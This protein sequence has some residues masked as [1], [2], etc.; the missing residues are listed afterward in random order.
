MMHNGDEIRSIT[1]MKTGSDLGMYGSYS[2]FI[3]HKGFSR[4]VGLSGPKGS[5]LMTSQEAQESA[6]K[7]LD[8]QYTYWR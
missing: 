6:E 7:I 2:L 8:E 5:H 3:F 4:R 1:I